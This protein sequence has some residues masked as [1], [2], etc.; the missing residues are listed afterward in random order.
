MTSVT[1]LGA[2]QLRALVHVLLDNML[3]Q[4]YLMQKSDH[5]ALVGT[6]DVLIPIVLQAEA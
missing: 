3:L 5:G 2:L 1:H 6:C 4:L